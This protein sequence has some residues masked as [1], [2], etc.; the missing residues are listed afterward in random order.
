MGI[1]ATHAIKACL[2]ELRPAIKIQAPKPMMP[3]EI[4]TATALFIDRP[5]GK[6]DRYATRRA[7]TFLRSRRRAGRDAAIGRPVVY[8][9]Q[10]H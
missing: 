8:S 7:K 5:K 6:Q 3:A 9:E 2:R 1:T 4:T 10:V